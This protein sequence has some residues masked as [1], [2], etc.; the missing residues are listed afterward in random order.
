MVMEVLVQ[1]DLG[2]MCCSLSVEDVADGVVCVWEEFQC[3]NGMKDSASVK[4]RNG[5]N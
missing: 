1:T 4:K 5:C 3:V 2:G